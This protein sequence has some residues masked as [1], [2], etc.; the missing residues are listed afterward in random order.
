MSKYERIEEVGRNRFDH[1]EE[2]EKF[3]PFHDSLG[4]FSTANAGVSFTSTTRDPNKQHWADKAKLKEQKRQIEIAEQRAKDAT[5][6]FL[7]TLGNKNATDKE[8]ADALAAASHA[9]ADLKATKKPVHITTDQ[10]PDDPKAHKPA[11]DFKEIDTAGVNEMKKEM[12]A[13]YSQ[14]DIDQM[15]SH[16]GWGSKA[17]GYFGT[18]H[19]FDL[20][21]DLRSGKNIQD[22]KKDD[23]KTC[24]TLDKNMK[25]ITRDIKLFRM[26]DDGFFEQFGIDPH[27][28]DT[29]DNEMLKAV[30]KVYG[31]KG[32]TSTSY[33]MGK[34]VFKTRK[35]ELHIN[36]PKG[37]KAVIRPGDKEAE[38]LLERNTGMKING[39]KKVPGIFGGVRYVVDVEV[40]V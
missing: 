19:S 22:L 11:A 39:I 13:D 37:T 40:I 30:G 5:S 26:V 14:E 17:G 9:N 6:N 38:I 10:K 28:A 12:G 7:N 21:E 4:R 33:D 8:I 16:G 27:K 36:A 35:Y 2:V 31:N 20:N 24:E 18:G 1:L 25:P 32:Y 3:N 23:R 15:N 34:N 29:D